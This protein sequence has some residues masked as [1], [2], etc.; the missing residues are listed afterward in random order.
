VCVFGWV[1]GWLG[2][3]VWL[4]VC[5]SESLGMVVHSNLAFDLSPLTY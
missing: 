5:G 3:C 2:V 4:V 1:V